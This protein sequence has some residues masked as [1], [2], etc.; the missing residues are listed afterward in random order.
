MVDVNGEPWFVAKDVAR[1]LGYPE[2][3]LRQ[4][5]NLFGHVPDAW[6]G[7]NPIPT[8]GGIQEMLIISEQGL[9]FFLGRSDK[10]KALPYQMWVAGDVASALGYV[11]TTQAIRMHCEKS[12]DF[13]GVEMTA[14]A[15][16]K[17]L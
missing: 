14:T 3:S 12:K 2:S 17:V 15:N 1:A 7:R 11:D 9:Y 13:R 5:N 16:V 6:K 4:L 8:P 10:S